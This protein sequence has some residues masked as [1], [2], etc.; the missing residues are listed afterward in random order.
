M[1][2]RHSTLVFALALGLATASAADDTRTVFKHDKGTYEKVGD[3]KW[4]EK[5]GDD[6]FELTVRT[7]TKE[8]VML[9]DDVR[10]LNIS[11]GEKQAQVRKDGQPVSDKFAGEWVATDKKSDPKDNPK[12]DTRTLFKHAK[13]EGSY[14][15]VSEGKW[16]EKTGRNT[17]ELVEKM[18]DDKAIELV[19]DRRRLVIK[20]MKDVATV[21]PRDKIDATF[22]HGE[23]VVAKPMTDAKV[24]P[25]PTPKADK[26]VWK[27][28]AGHFEKTGDGK[29]TERTADGV[30]EWAEKGTS[31]FKLTLEDAAR[32]LTAEIKSDSALVRTPGQKISDGKTLKGEWVKFDPKADLDPKADGRTVWQSPDGTFELSAPGVWTETAGRTVKKFIQKAVTEEYVELVDEEFKARWVRLTDKA[33]LERL[34]E[35]NKYRVEGRPGGWVKSTKPDAN[36]K[37]AELGRLAPEEANGISIAVS[38]DGKRVAKIIGKALASELAVV[39]LDDGK[40]VQRW[41]DISGVIL[42]EWSA[43]GSTLAAMHQGEAKKDGRPSRVLVWDTTTWEEKASFEVAGFTTGLALSGDGKTVATVSPVAER[44][45]KAIVWDV[46][47]KK[48]VFTTP[49]AAVTPKVALS[50]DGRTFAV[51]QVSGTNSVV[52]VYDLTTRKLK[53]TV[54]ARSTF[55]LS[56]DGTKVAFTAF[57]KNIATVNVVNLKAASPPQIKL[58]DYLVD[59]IHFADSD[60]HLVLAGGTNKGD[61]VRVFAVKTGAQVDAFAVGKESLGRSLFLLRVT[62]DS[63][64]LVT[65]GTDRYTR[66]WSTPFG[67]KKDDKK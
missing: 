8:V 37:F 9:R 6:T 64:R 56:A 5:R 23:W 38:P 34:T 63:T 67:E 27:Y 35:L 32:K 47:T 36:V 60:R 39:E 58:T 18:R 52:G 66:V 1:L 12:A 13:G 54:N 50:A 53:T 19:D 28:D 43:D 20:I 40:V 22:V 14:E 24:P 45:V 41:K 11:L 29:W 51:N 55:T 44:E 57:D 62:P 59:S 25:V 2:L 21:R 31:P 17:F 15:F 46:P 10:K 4:V 61:E 30:F 3:G 42:L 65:Y 33:R 16:V 26:T 7:V 48:E 49:A